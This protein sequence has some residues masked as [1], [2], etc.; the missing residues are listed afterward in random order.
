MFKKIFVAAAMFFILTCFTTAVAKDSAGLVSGNLTTADAAG[1]GIGYLGGFV[2]FGDN[3]A[4][5]FGTFTY[6]VSDYTDIRFKLGFA[7]AD[8]PESDP[9]IFLGADFKY[10]LMDYDDTLH[11]NPFDLATGVFMEFVNYEGGSVLQLGGNL[12]GS[13]P[14]RFESG[15]RM[16]PYA[17]LN[18]RME[19]IDFDAADESDTDFQGGLN[20]GAKFELNRDFNLY[21]EFQLDGNTGIFFGLDIRVF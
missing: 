9:E 5:V 19:R 16:I 8:A 12:I 11:N 18:I 20:A 2:G 1:T 3:A 21:G 14:Y 10:E 6:G 15:H 17:R 7:D 13:I 4:A